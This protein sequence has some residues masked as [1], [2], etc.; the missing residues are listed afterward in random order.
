MFRKTNTTTVL[1]V[2][3]TDSAAL[4]FMALCKQGRADE[5]L[6][7]TREANFPD[8][9]VGLNKMADECSHTAQGELDREFIL[10]ME[11]YLLN[12]QAGRPLS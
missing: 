4:M 9:I 5:A 10:A 1:T 8:L 2:E 3:D 11:R 7:L 12:Q 6:K